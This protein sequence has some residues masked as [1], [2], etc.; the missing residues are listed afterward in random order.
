MT[1]VN[2]S[3]CT[4]SS[5]WTSN[6]HNTPSWRLTHWFMQC[7]VFDRTSDG[8]HLLVSDVISEQVCAEAGEL[9]AAH[10]SR[11]WAASCSSPCRQTLLSQLLY[12]R[13]SWWKGR[14]KCL[15]SDPSCCLGWILDFCALIVMTW[16]VCVV[17]SCSVHSLSNM[18][19]S[20]SVQDFT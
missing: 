14:K 11:L 13:G 17:T 9:Y 1:D 15:Y 3:A 5:Y 2:L 10:V 18:E 12:S 7:F 20:P 8:S 6:I 4:V 16:T 19:H